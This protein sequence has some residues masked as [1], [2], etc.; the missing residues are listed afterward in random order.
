M[1]AMA[2]LS[3][4]GATTMALL[5]ERVRLQGDMPGFT[6]AVDAVMGA[7]RGEA[8]RDFSMCRTVLSDPVLT[9]R[10]LKLANSGMYAAFGQR[11]DT[12]TKAVLVLGAETIGHLALGLKLVEELGRNRPDTLH[13]HEEME[14]AVLAGMVAEQV[15]AANALRDPEAAVV[16]AILHAL[17]RMMVTFYLPERWALLQAQRDVGEQAELDVLGVPLDAIGRAAA[18]HWGFPR[19]L[20]ACM[21]SVAPGERGSAPGREQWL[22]AIA[23]LSSR[24]AEALWHDDPAGDTE[25]QRLAGAYAP[26]LGLAPEQIVAAVGQAKAGA[27]DELAIAPLAR[28][29]L[30]RTRELA[31]ARKRSDGNRVMMAGVAELREALA[32]G[33]STRMMELALEALHRGLDLSRSLVFIH[34]RREALYL[35]RMG[36]GEGVEALAPRLRFGDGYEATVFHAALGSDR[37]TVIEHPREPGFAAKLPLWWKQS[38]GDA[39]SFVIL[40]LTV[41]GTPSGFLYGDWVGEA[42]PVTPGPVE[43]GLLNDVRS[44]LAR[45]LDPRHQIDVA[46]R[47]QA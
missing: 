15:A 40:P 9:Q 18:E 46:A 1:N 13:A 29:E 7:L 5:W 26:M 47:V 27:V 31:R 25:V 22:A 30:K 20:V 21:R 42:A 24:C 2:E 41:R 44:L 14:K 23:T 35:A 28:P 32:Q 39:R 6:R 45:S 43:L 16:C 17:G 19:S 10:V 4:K 37:V 11:I 12:V 36:L 34:H 3:P 8:G 33:S 38:L